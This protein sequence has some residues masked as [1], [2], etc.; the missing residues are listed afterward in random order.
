MLLPKTAASKTERFDS[1]Y[2]RLRI[3]KPT[4]EEALRDGNQLYE[5]YS[6]HLSHMPG[7][8]VHNCAQVCNETYLYHLSHEELPPCVDCL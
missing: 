8:Y 1:S 5:R 7:L 2:L 3:L 4:P 6:L